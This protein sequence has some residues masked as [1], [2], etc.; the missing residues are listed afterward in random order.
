MLTRLWKGA[1]G[2]HRL[3]GLQRKSF[4]EFAEIFFGDF[5]LVL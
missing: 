1:G 2:E 5:E 4:L 3:A